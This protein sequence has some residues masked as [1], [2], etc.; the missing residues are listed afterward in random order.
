LRVVPLSSRTLEGASTVPRLCSASSRSTR[1]RLLPLLARFL[2]YSFLCFTWRSSLIS[3]RLLSANSGGAD[4][5][6]TLLLRPSILLLHFVASI[7]VGSPSFT[8]LGRCGSPACLFARSLLSSSYHS[9]PPF[10]LARLRSPYSDGAAHLPASSLGPFYPPLTLRCLCSGWLA[11]V[12]PTRAVRLT[13][14]P[15]LLRPS[16]LGLPFV[17]SVRVG[18]PPVTRL[19]GCGIL[20]ASP[21][22]PFYGML[23]LRLLRLPRR[24]SCH[25]TRGCGSPARLS[26]RTLL[27]ASY[28]SL[29]PF[30]LARLRS[31]DSEGAA[32]LPD[33]PLGLFYGMLAL[34]CLRSGWL[35]FVHPTRAV[36]LT[37]TTL[38]SDSST[39]LLPFACSVLVG[40]PSFARLGRCGSPACLLSCALLLSA[41]PSMPLF[42]LARLHSP[43]SG[44]RLTCA[45]LLL[46]PSTAC[47]PFDASVLVGSPSF[48]RLGRRGSPARLSSRTLLRHAC[49]STP[50]FWLARLRSPD[51]DG[52]AHLPTNSTKKYAAF[53]FFY[54]P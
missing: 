11:F 31:P 49:P 38:L 46:R 44:V 12:R 10:E 21:L 50:P 25:P 51:S 15:L 37:R 18:S 27:P 29:A 22:A 54:T 52:A 2:S 19:G 45:T 28:P 43:D 39:R 35:A 23:T 53:A 40:S 13:C 20:P 9:L 16:I 3:P 34:R 42:W 33:S 30:W 48:T 4:Y 24:A 6:A 7:L 1:C 36:R 17:A 32:H 47:L 14:L 41:Y 5:C 8:R 26:S